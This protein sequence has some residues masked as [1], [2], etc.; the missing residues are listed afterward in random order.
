MARLGDAFLLLP[1]GC[2]FS[3]AVGCSPKTSCLVPGRAHAAGSAL[4]LLSPPFSPMH[5][6]PG[7][8]GLGPAG[9]ASPSLP[10]NLRSLHGEGRK[11][12]LEREVPC[13]WG[14]M[15]WWGWVLPGFLLLVSRAWC[16]GAGGVLGP[17]PVPSSAAT[18]T[19]VGELASSMSLLSDLCSNRRCGAAQLCRC[20][21]DHD[22][23]T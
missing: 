17:C 10:P 1:W 5:T 9:R 14:C 15:L 22:G 7:G 21:Q 18:G 6:S 19:L 23:V 3:R 11:G 13:S 12:T 8:T 2:R 16:R 20:N 4:A